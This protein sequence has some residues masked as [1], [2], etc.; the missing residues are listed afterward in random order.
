[1]RNKIRFTLC[2]KFCP[3]TTG[4]GAIFPVVCALVV[5]GAKCW[6]IN[7]YASPTPFWDQWDAE[8]AILYPR[9]FA[10]TLHISDLIALH[11]EHRILTT[12]LWALLLLELGGYWDPLLQMVTNT[13]VLGA[14][15]VL[16]VAAFRPFLDRA[17]WLAFGL[18]SLV[19]FS[20]PF[21]SQNTL[22]G[23][24]SQWYFLLLFSVAGLFAIIH[25]AAFT[26]RW[27]LAMLLLILS[28]FSVAS[29]ALSVA[30]AFAICSLQTIAR[31]RSGLSEW[32]ALA[33]LAAVMIV[34]L[35]YIPVLPYHA[36]LK[37]HSIGQFLYA[38][39]TIAV[40]P[41]MSG[42]VIMLTLS[43][44]LIHAPAWLTSID[45]IRRRPPLADRRWLL[46]A[47]TGWLALQAT[48][49][50]YGR[51]AGPTSSRYL[52]VFAIGLPLNAACL[53]LFWRAS[54]KQLP[55][56]RLAFGMGAIWLLFVLCGLALNT[57]T[58]SQAELANEQAQGQDWTK[59]LR[60]YLDTGDIG[61]LENQPFLHIPY[62]DAQ[63]LA[64]IASSPVIRA[65]LPPALV[66]KANA[67]RTQE[68]GLARF[69]GRLIEAF[70]DAMLRWGVLLMPTCSLLLLLA[71][72]AQWQR[73][74]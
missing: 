64:E 58:R 55:Q 22:D 42:P 11:N 43:A 24:Q 74:E 71:W 72:A 14:F 34:M 13:L 31:R 30:A 32:L 6:M 56:R 27:W 35:W 17:S 15:V 49:I 18:F 69:T 28:Y 16:F 7:R 45:V 29:G 2:V 23:F 4:F 48:T 73:R 3:N 37:A 67:A 41:L 44:I 63:R 20:L 66:G 36:P 50:A 60:A 59:N 1:M 54:E 9:Y 70:K 19:I 47:L 51:A 38:L 62:P 57:I 5:I 26:P 40:W 8:G 33:I 21:G 65:I 39:V 52:D 12:R 61:A 53:L 46:V 10:G 68:R 25:A